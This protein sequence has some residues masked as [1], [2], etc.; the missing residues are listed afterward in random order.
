[1]TC[2]INVLIGAKYIG[3]GGAKTVL[4]NNLNNLGVFHDG[5]LHL[6]TFV[7]DFPGNLADILF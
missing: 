4:K 1:M 3:G 6:V 7:I 5:P 2:L